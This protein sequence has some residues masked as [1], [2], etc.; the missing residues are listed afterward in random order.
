MKTTYV[1]FL[2]LL[3]STNLISQEFSIFQD[4]EKNGIPNF[5]NY[6]DMSKSYIIIS[7]N[8]QNINALHGHVFIYKQLLD[9]TWQY[10]SLIDNKNTEYWGKTL[11]ITDK[12]A[13]IA[14]YTDT[15][16]GKVWIYKNTND[17]FELF[18]TIQ[19]DIPEI[20]SNFG[21]SISVDS[22]HLAISAPKF[23]SR[24]CVYIFD[25]KND[26]WTQ[27]A[28]IK[29]DVTNINCLA[30]YDIKL[31]NNKLLI[32]SPYEK[33][34]ENSNGRAYFYSLENNIWSLKNTILPNEH[35]QAQLF[36]YSVDFNNTQIFVSA[37]GFENN[38]GKIYI[39][40]YNNNLTLIQDIDNPNSNDNDFFGNDISVN[41]NF[42]TVSSL[43]D[44][45]ASTN[46]YSGSCFVFK[47]DNKWTKI[48]NIF[49]K[50]NFEN[51]LYFGN[52]IK[53]ID[54]TIVIGMPGNKLKHVY[55]YNLAIPRITK[56]PTDM[57][58]VVSQTETFF[59]VK[60]DSAETF[61]WQISRD[62]NLSFSNLPQNMNFLSVNNDTLFIMPDNMLDNYFFRCKVSNKYGCSISNSAKLSLIFDSQVGKIFPNPNTGNFNLKL[63]QDYNGWT[64]II[65][66]IHKD[67]LFEKKL[68][69]STTNID[70]GKLP[71]GVYILALINGKQK[72][73]HKFIAY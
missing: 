33:Y 23:N 71:A 54:S 17:K 6:V 59:Y 37:P 41:A 4:I 31:K 26:K 69:N 62:S 60:A 28:I 2:T 42:L 3:I 46:S 20:G 56:H 32:G 16:I 5:G 14:S 39:Y 53:M 43:N 21:F 40:E 18:Q 68:D 45:I 8:S 61:Q 67:I 24:G 38:S 29:P 9:N 70:L 30:G 36:G 58:S 48:Q 72:E 15:T 66:N 52:S 51:G 73:Y 57:D 44:Y 64:V 25:L 34:V 1:L 19:A 63:F 22:N 7:D 65:Y 27:S 49:P 12:Y 11:A 13:F 50:F 10:I 47:K 55:I 35:Q